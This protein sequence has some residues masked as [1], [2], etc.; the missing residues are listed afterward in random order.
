MAHPQVNNVTCSLMDCKVENDS[1][2]VIWNRETA[3]QRICNDVFNNSFNACIDI[4]FA[5][6]DDH[7][8]TYSSL[9]ISDDCIRLRP[10]TKVNIRAFMQ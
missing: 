8:K 1:G 3:S 9:T 6:L 10:A 7:W 4:T 2:G 5:K